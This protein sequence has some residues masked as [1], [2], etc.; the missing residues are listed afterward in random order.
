MLIF[1]HVRNFRIWSQSL[2]YPTSNCNNVRGL[3]RKGHWLWARE[4]KN[5]NIERVN[6]RGFSQDIWKR[7]YL[8]YFWS[9]AVAPD[10]PL[11]KKSWIEINRIEPYVEKSIV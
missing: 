11:R 3:I 7:L 4:E 1:I 5:W 10:D 9:S 8:F 2:R 6:E